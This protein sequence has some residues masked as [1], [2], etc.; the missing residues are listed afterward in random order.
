MY[1]SSKL[2]S[3]PTIRSDDL[4]VISSLSDSMQPSAWAMRKN[5]ETFSKPLSFKI[6]EVNSD[7]ICFIKEGA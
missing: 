2:P 7:E 5:F 1:S 3:N 6:G 4:V